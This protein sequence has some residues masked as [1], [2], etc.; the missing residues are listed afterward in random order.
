MND[1]ISKK[2]VKMHKKR[3]IHYGNAINHQKVLK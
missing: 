1:S 3:Y 2:M